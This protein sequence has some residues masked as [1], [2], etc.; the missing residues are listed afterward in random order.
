M[1]CALKVV[2]VGL[3]LIL[4]GSLSLD[5]YLWIGQ[6]VLRQCCVSKLYL[7]V[8]S[9][10]NSGPYAHIWW[11]L[12]CVPDLL[13]L[14][15]LMSDEFYLH[16]LAGMGCDHD[17]VITLTVSVALVA[18]YLLNL[19]FLLQIISLTWKAV[20]RR[21]PA[22]TGTSTAARCSVSSSAVPRVDRTLPLSQ[23]TQ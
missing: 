19:L 16:C 18:L 2:K 9:C 13:L 12:L 1:S 4:M 15:L 6:H 10:V 3:S 22:R 11:F 21:I 14:S 5:I 17:L 8:P 7:T 23:Q 20:R